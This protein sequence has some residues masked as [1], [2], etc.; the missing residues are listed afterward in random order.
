MSTKEKLDEMNEFEEG[1]PSIVF[2]KDKLGE[3]KLTTVLEMMSKAD[4]NSITVGICVDRLI[5][6]TDEIDISQL[7]KE[8]ESQKSMFPFY[9]YKRISDDETVKIGNDD[10]IMVSYIVSFNNV[11]RYQD[12]YFRVVGDR[13]IMI[14]L[15]FNDEK[16]RD[17]ILDAFTAY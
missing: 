6:K 2:S 13:V 15:D 17:N 4:D 3:M 5:D 14:V 7:I 9:N 12:S 1:T 8:F 11:F 16:A 10:Y